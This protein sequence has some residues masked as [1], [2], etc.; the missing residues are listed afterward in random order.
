M[1]HESTMRIKMERQ[2]KKIS[3]WELDRDTDGSW[4]APTWRQAFLR[5][6]Q[7]TAPLVVRAG[8]VKVVSQ[9]IGDRSLLLRCLGCESI[10]LLGGC[11]RC[12]NNSL[13]VV[14]ETTGNDPAVLEQSFLCSRCG[15]ST[16]R[17]WTCTRCGTSN[18]NHMTVG[19]A[20]TRQFDKKR[21]GTKM[22]P[23]AVHNPDPGRRINIPE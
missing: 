2:T 4:S 6:T 10:F 7:A 5:S 16:G 14:I 18:P 20:T 22:V 13:G 1:A 11:P 17:T 9:G 3:L 12:G 23:E 8:R 21:S 15:H 19:Y